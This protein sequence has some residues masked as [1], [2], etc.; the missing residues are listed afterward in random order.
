MYCS[1]S[2]NNVDSRIRQIVEVLVDVRK[3]G[4]KGF[5]LRFTDYQTGEFFK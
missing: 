1:P 4:K 3:I 2:I 5:S